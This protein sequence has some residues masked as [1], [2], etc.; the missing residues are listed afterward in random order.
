MLIHPPLSSLWIKFPK[1]RI[2][3]EE[4]GTS[5]LSLDHSLLPGLHFD[6]PF[7]TIAY[8]KEKIACLHNLHMKEKPLQGCRLL[9]AQPWI[10]NNNSCR[11]FLKSYL[12]R[13]DTW[14]DTE[15]HQGSWKH[16]QTSPIMWNLKSNESEHFPE[17][18][19][20]GISQ[21]TFCIRCSLMFVVMLMLYTEQTMGTRAKALLTDCCHKKSDFFLDGLPTRL[22][23]GY[24]F[25]TNIILNLISII[26]I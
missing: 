18:Y 24:K 23:R 25:G 17:S 13:W 8:G 7:L 2:G 19:L 16:Q 21:A 10:N 1:D 15:W 4:L 3:L 14:G 9:Y 6:W 12:S 11:E 22:C 26:N 5:A 20:S